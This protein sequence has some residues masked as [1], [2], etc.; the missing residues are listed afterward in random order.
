MLETDLTSETAQAYV[1]IAHEALTLAKEGNS[2]GGRSMMINFPP[3]RTLQGLRAG[4]T[5][6]HDRFI[7]ARR[8]NLEKVSSLQLNPDPSEIALNAACGSCRKDWSMS[9]PPCSQCKLMDAMSGDWEN[10]LWTY[11]KR[12]TSSAVGKGEGTFRE[13]GAFPR[14]LR[15][16]LQWVSESRRLQQYT[17]G[18]SKVSNC[19]LVVYTY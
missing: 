9:G 8:I 7:T 1:K 3:F 10:L 18:A 17:G 14:L 11:R 2:G 12:Q 16:V 6:L 4:L 13:E 15:V 5:L 19:H